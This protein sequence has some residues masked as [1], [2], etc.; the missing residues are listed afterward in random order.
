ML[1]PDRNGKHYFNDKRILH[2]TAFVNSDLD[3]V[4]IIETDDGERI[5]F[6]STWDDLNDI[7]KHVALERGWNI[8]EGRKREPSEPTHEAE[9]IPFPL[10][11]KLSSLDCP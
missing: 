2:Y 3:I 7:E 11:S 4:E 1:I 6:R 9:I 8:P 10:S 5:V